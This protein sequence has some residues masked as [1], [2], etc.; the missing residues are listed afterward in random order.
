MSGTKAS[1]DTDVAVLNATDRL[2]AV[3]PGTPNANVMIPGTVVAE[4]VRDVIAAT[5]V[6][7]ANVTL[8]VNDAGDTITIN[9]SSGSFLPLTGGTLTG[10][11]A[12]R[13]STDAT[14]TRRFSVASDGTISIYSIDNTTVD[15]TLSPGGA[16]AARGTV[17]AYNG[18]STLYQLAQLAGPTFTGR[19]AVTPA[20]LTDAATTTLNGAAGNYFTWTMG[21]SRTLALSGIVAGTTYLVEIKQDATG[22]R[23]V[24]W[25][26]GF[27]WSGGTV[28][29]LSTAANAIDLLTF[30]TL[31]G[32]TFRAVLTK[33][34]A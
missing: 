8:A 26:S 15:F 16:L 24:T 13:N 34:F 7:G 19:V 22:S 4:Y 32:S 12:L 11:L 20:T 33:G 21:G 2:L 5:L 6:A 1:A 9:A 29:V 31:D 25:P 18:G 17:S 14:K 28:G 10:D 27:T 23:V 3:R 30:A